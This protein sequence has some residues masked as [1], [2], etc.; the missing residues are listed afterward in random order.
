MSFNDNTRIDSGRVRDSRGRGGRGGKIA[1]GGGGILVLLIASLLGINPALLEELGLGG[2][3]V[4]EQPADGSGTRAID[5]CKTGAD[6]DARTDC[7]IVATTQSLDAFWV[8]YLERY[9][10]SLAEPAV[11]IFADSVSTR[12]GEAS[13]AVGPFYCPADGTAYFDTGF[14]G[15]LSSRFGSDGGALAEEYVVAHEYGHHVQNHLGAL[16]NSQEGGTGPRSGAVRVEL[17]ADCFAGLWAAHASQ[18]RNEEGETFMEPFTEADLR[19]ALSAAAAVGDDRIQQ[20]ATGRVSPEGWTHGSSAQR[21]AW[22]LEG[23][24]TGDINRCDTLKA[25]DLDRPAS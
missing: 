3:T 2:D 1:A 8:P 6:A 15:Q 25:A 24:R 17:Q 10:E 20:A 18:T 21:Q 4:Q 12:C 22:F 11:E 16:R 7:R 14:F 23:Y 13:S 19:S 5:E 9:G